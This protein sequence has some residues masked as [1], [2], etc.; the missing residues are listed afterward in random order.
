MTDKTLTVQQKS[1]YS[2]VE[3][4]AKEHWDEYPMF[5]PALN[6]ELRGKVFLKEAL[7]LTGM[8]ISINKLP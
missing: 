6:R 5:I 8:E 4:G 2:V 1:N 7:G 3:V